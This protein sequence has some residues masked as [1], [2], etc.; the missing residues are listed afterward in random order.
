MKLCV[1][2]CVCA[3]ARAPV[4]MRACVRSSVRVYVYECARVRVCV[5]VCVCVCVFARARAHECA[6]VRVCVRACACVCVWV[7]GR[8]CEKSLRERQNYAMQIRVCTFLTLH[9]H[10]CETH[11][12]HRDIRRI[13]REKHLPLLL[14][15][16]LFTPSASEGEQC[17]TRAKSWER[18]FI[19]LHSQQKRTSGEHTSLQPRKVSSLDRP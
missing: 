12:Y 15:L 18:Q 3:F 17:Q 13:T 16:L 14:L 19:Y 7:C 10:R 8:A 1:C 4:C 9:V 5:C 11:V 6:C 2:V